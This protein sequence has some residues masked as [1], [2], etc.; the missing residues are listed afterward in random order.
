[1]YI[2]NAAIGREALSKKRAFR[3]L[4][5]PGDVLHFW[6]DDAASD[7]TKLP[8]RD[9]LWWSGDEGVDRLVA[10]RSVAIL[11]RL[12]SGLGEI[13][14]DKGAAE[15]LAAIV[16]L[17]QFTRNIFRDTEFAF[18]NDDLALKLCKSGLAKDDDK[19][20]AP[21]K[22]WFFYLPLMHSENIDDQDLCV[23]LFEI[24]R[25]QADDVSKEALEDAYN[26]AIKH[27]DVIAEYGRFPH[28]NKVLGR[29]STPA[30]EEYLAQPGAGF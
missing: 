13:W 7:P 3:P 1:M 17:D 14:A 20:L 23:Q 6:F 5:T 27:R 19:V 25:D 4:Q 15:R 22:R 11:A 24:L 18:E 21:I 8:E 9:N 12:A 29:I 2:D 10:S 30:E 16:A 26:F 28:R